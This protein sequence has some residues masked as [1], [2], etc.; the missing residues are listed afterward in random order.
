MELRSMHADMWTMSL[1][2]LI[3]QIHRI[4]KTIYN[5]EELVSSSNEVLWAELKPIFLF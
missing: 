3:A 1:L 4:I 2:F 5:N